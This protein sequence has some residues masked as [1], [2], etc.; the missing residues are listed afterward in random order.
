M[1]DEEIGRHGR[2][3]EPAT[4]H[5]PQLARTGTRTRGDREVV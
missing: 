4:A 2:E 1:R 3:E 5:I